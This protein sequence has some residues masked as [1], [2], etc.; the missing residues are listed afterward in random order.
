VRSR[1]N[2]KRP[3]HIWG[4]DMTKM[5][6][7]HWGWI[8]LV[9]VLDRYTKEIIGYNLPFGAKTEEWIEALNVAMNDRFPDG[10]R[11]W[12]DVFEFEAALEEWGIKYNNEYLHQ[13]LNYRT[14]KQCYEE[15]VKEQ[16]KVGMKMVP[17]SL[18][19]PLINREHYGIEFFTWV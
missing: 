14:P 5:N 15:R 10:V 3:N 9:E 4:T 2:A 8:Y 7:K 17:L 13:G 1:S 6:L 18:F 16:T 19:Y 12:E 11:K